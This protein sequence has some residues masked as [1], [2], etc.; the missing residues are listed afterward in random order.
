MTPLIYP[1]TAIRTISW[2]V[3]GGRAITVASPLEC[4]LCHPAEIMLPSAP[5]TGIVNYYQLKD[6]LMGHVDRSESVPH[7]LL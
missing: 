6:T 2:T 4:G 1:S 3:T 7:P 5:D